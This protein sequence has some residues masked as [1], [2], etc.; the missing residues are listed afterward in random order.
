MSLALGASRGTATAVVVWAHGLGDS[1]RGWEPFARSLARVLPH[2]RWV[3]PCAPQNPVT[4]NGGMVMTS[5]MDLECIPISLARPGDNGKHMAASLAAIHR[6]IDDEIRAGIPADRI[7][8]GGFSQGGALAL[9]AAASFP[10]RLAGAVVHSG[11]ALPTQ[12]IGER[13]KAPEAA[14]ASR[15]TPFLVCHGEADDVVTFDNAPAVH[16]ML[17]S[18]GCAAELKT[19][20]GVG[21]GTCPRGSSERDVLAF[22]QRVVP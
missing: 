18:A 3:L 19:Y 6:I 9:A 7:V 20:P 2:V 1:P 11:W 8:V 13:L 10:Q 14:A 17:R 16:A 22:L 4:C 12:K 15:K 5:W 21:H